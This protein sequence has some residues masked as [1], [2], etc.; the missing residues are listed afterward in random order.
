[1]KLTK[2]A[3]NKFIIWTSSRY[4]EQTK[5]QA[6][7]FAYDLLSGKRTD[8]ETFMLECGSFTPSSAMQ[9]GGSYFVNVPEQYIANVRAHWNTQTNEYDILEEYARLEIL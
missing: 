9:H 2:S 5:A 4:N 3:L 6:V 7:Q 1:M 8:Y